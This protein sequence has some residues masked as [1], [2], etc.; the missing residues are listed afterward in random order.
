MSARRPASPTSG[1]RRRRSD[2]TRSDR[3]SSSSSVESPASADEEWN[4]DAT[5]FVEGYDAADE[6]ESP[7][8]GVGVPA[9]VAVIVTRNPGARFDDL[10]ASI[11]AQE[12]ANLVTLVVDAGSDSD[13]TE[14]VAEVLPTAFVKRIDAGG[15]A[16]AANAALG[17]VDGAS[18]YL[19]LHDDVELGK[20]A[21]Q[22]MV[23]E[24]FRSNAGIVGAKLLDGADRRT[25]TDVGA[26]IDKFGFLWPYAEPGELD[27]SQHD[28]IREAFVVS[29]AAMLVRCDL[30]RDLGG[31]S[32]DIDGSGEELDLCWRARVAG[33]RT[34]VMPAAQVFHHAESTFDKAHERGLRLALRHQARI[35][36]ACYSALTLLRILPQAMVLGVLDL[37]GALL[38]GRWRQ[39]GDVFTAFMWNLGHLPRTL[40]IRRSTQKSRRTPDD[41][42]RRLQIKGS[43]RFTNFFHA[44]T[45]RDRSLGQAVAAAARGMSGPNDAH[46]TGIWGIGAFL[47]A[48]VVLV[49]G[50]RSLITGGVPVVRE[51]VTNSPSGDLLREWWSGWRS[52][53][54]GQS[55]GSPTVAFVVGAL[56][57]MTFGSEGLV[58]TVV[59]LAPLGV[60]ALGAWRLLR[61]VGSPL[62]RTAVLVAYLANPIPYNAIAEGRWQAL[63]VWALAPSIVA[64]LAAAGAF[65]PFADT[66]RAER[67][68]LQQTFALGLIVA[69]GATVAPV[70][71][72]VVALLA[73]VMAVVVGAGSRG[74]LGR[75]G[76]VTLGS[77]AVSA[78]VHLPWTISV[79]GGANRVE[80]L[81]G[82]AAGRGAP[83]GV[84][85]ALVFDTGAHGT[86]LSGGLLVAIAAAVLITV[87]PVFRWTLFGLVSAL[88][89]F[90]LVAL[91]GLLA[92]SVA[93]PVPEV[94]LVPAA[95]GAALCVGVAAEAITTTLSGTA[96][97]IRHV[98]AV[99]CAV[100]V[101]V[102]VL[103]LL[104]D[105]LNGR[106]DAPTS[107]VDDALESLS[108]G[109]EIE[110]F[111]TLWIGDADAVAQAG[112]RF[113]DGM[114][115]A[116]S[117]GVSSGLPDL[118]PPAKGR[119]SGAGTPSQR[120]SSRRDEPC[121]SLPCA[122]RYPLCGGAGA[123]R[124]VAL[125]ANAVRDRCGDEGTASP[126][127]RPV[128]DRC[129]P[130]YRG[131]REPGRAS[132]LVDH[133]CRCRVGVERRGG[134]E[135]RRSGRAATGRHVGS[136][137]DTAGWRTVGR[138]DVDAVG[139]VGRSLDD[140]GRRR[141]GR[142]RFG[143]RLGVDR[144]DRHRW[145]RVVGVSNP[146]D[147]GRDAPR[148]VARVG[149]GGG[150]SPRNA[151]VDRMCAPA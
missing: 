91:A 41:E 14:R 73:V 99:L 146:A 83:I 60:G 49:G 44:Y 92:P 69:I 9:V 13:P 68:V 103:P 18:F 31:F 76:V 52:A 112:W 147:S 130:G 134:A 72:L 120:R 100:G 32:T 117:T 47:I 51:F 145:Q 138:P 28:A 75:L 53:G 1:S 110:N 12:Y 45:A 80:V 48:A 61:G 131:V 135:P 64:R 67:S 20:G 2:T 43:A 7:V 109:A 142:T 151:V 35:M 38:R 23:E 21:V 26:S 42:I 46:N 122:V 30:F 121:R 71:V 34:V 24:A 59:F 56:N 140:E 127:V 97:G 106:W 22:A 74:N 66:E 77:L 150:Q 82:N 93:L 133:R 36:L 113:G 88:V 136:A 29:G 81:L 25:L 27:Q 129:G 124:A 118:F 4:P 96:F 70:I 50:S 111:R 115:F 95:L 85:E 16:V 148:A 33:A 11:S 126:A 123:A 87:G 132:G 102:A 114:K 137:P 78:L 128:V 5:P 62:A 39:A 125:R 10:L 65:E 79:L 54:L 116:V 104:L 84:S 40:S 105:S 139:R 58:R 101:L 3:P 6:A 108:T 143:E 149:G 63:V 57:W 17:T 55:G 15:F 8:A 94:L 107:D 19:V 37:V 144:A 90:G 86:F 89:G 98:A 141:R 119:R